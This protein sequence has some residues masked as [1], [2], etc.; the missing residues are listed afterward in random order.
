MN[1]DLCFQT[2]SELAQQ[3]ALRKLSP[4]ELTRAYLERSQTL[5]ETL[6]TIITLTADHAMQQAAAAEKEIVAG[7]LRGPLHGIPYAVKD[8]LDTKGIRTTGGS[9]IYRDRVPDRNA[10]VIDRLNTAGAV[11]IAKLA[12]NEFASGANN[13]NLVPQPRN[14]WKLDRS[15]AGSSSGP[16]A[17]TAAA[18]NAFSMGSETG[19]SIM[20]PSAANG[21][22]GANSKSRLKRT[23]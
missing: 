16:G 19:G 15:P 21:V 22:S 9:T 14:P 11:L 5:N 12:M 10:T 4:V 23:R 17:S 7:H 8:L 1:E 6:S 3:I 18:M 20:G 2:V 13:N